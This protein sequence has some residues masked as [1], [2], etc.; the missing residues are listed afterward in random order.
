MRT[1]TIAAALSP[2]LLAALPAMAQVRPP[3]PAPTTTATQRSGHAPAGRRLQFEVTGGVG[4]TAVD[5]DTWAGKPAN[6]WNTLA[7]WGAARLLLPMGS[8]LRLGVE[9]GYHYHFWYHAYPGGTVSWVYQYDVA[10]THVAGMVRFPVGTHFSADLG[11]GLHLFDAGA[12]PG[13]L[14]ALSYDIPVGN[15]A[16]PIG[17]RADY[18]LTNPALLPIV[19]NT[20]VR[21]S[22]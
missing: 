2:L 6:D 3:T 10:A 22:F 7:Y 8:S 18:V 5:V 4:Y 20:G 15:L 11:A 13:V 14:A 1:L 9:V 21:F 12:K 19:L 16:I 17:V